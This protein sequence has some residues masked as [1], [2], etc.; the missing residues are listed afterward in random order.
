MKSNY[1]PVK[2]LPNEIVDTFFEK[3]NITSL[4]T[5]CHILFVDNFKT[6]IASYQKVFEDYNMVSNIFYSCKANKANAFIYHA[7][8]ERCG[9]EVSSIY[10]LMDALKYTKRIICSGPAKSL[11]YINLSIDNGAII[12]VDDVYELQQIIKLRKE[13]NILIRI[14]NIQNCKSRFG[15]CIEFLKQCITWIKN[16]KVNLLGFSFHINNYSINDRI[17][18]IKQLVQIVKLENITIKYI[19]IGGGFPVNYCRAEDYD[20]FINHNNQDMY[21]SKKKITDFYPYSNPLAGA[22][23]FRKIILEVTKVLGNIE[24][25]IEPGRSLLNNSGVSV[26]GVSYLKRLVSDN[27]VIVDGNINFLS[28]Q[29]FNSD[30][31]IEPMLIKKYK[32]RHTVP[33]LAS[34]AGNLCLEQDMLC[35][36]KILFED[37]PENGD[38]LVYFNTAGYQMDSNES[39]FHKIP[40]PIKYVVTQNSDYVL[41]EDEMY[42]NYKNN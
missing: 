28:E 34:I 20:F 12:S 41:I 36:R 18:A 5:P 40:I 26:F 42:D 35:W 22:E 14:S 37:I 11:E 21:F 3:V 8:A 4:A 19:D 29:W 27:I 6:N 23:F 9:I 33:I 31:L 17:E 10:E 24:I 1:I 38:K 15:I 30:Y 7:V 32:R 2:A 13:A 16:S 39:S 25:I